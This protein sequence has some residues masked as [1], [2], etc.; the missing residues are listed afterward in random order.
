MMKR[1]ARVLIGAAGSVAALLAILTVV[2][3]GTVRQHLEAWHFQLTRETVLID[4]WGPDCEF[5][6]TR[7]TLRSLLCATAD[8]LDVPVVLDVQLF[9]QDPT[10]P[11]T[12]RWQGLL[13]G[14]LV[15]QYLR[16]DGY[17]IIEQHHPRRAYVVIRAAPI[18][19]PEV[20]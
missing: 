19:L 13:T 6:G 12:E 20:R 17:R 10:L 9:I 4:G 8:Q 3:W 18:D 11:L 1:R 7:R 5:A 15:L 2:Y 16:E 14:D